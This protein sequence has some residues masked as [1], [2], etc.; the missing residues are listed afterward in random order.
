[1]LECRYDRLGTV[2]EG[3]YGTAYL[4]KRKRSGHEIG[5]DLLVAKK[6]SI[7]HLRRGEQSDAIREADLL[8]SLSHPNIVEFVDSFVEDSHILYIIMGFADAGDLAARIQ[9]AQDLGQA[10]PE[11][12][13][14]QVL[15]QACRSRL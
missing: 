8:R 6:I 9:T 11:R 12:E 13:V 1:M 7:S 5:Q 2:G 14:M 4:V 10:I 15:A 3:A